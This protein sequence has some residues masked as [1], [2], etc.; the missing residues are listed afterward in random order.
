MVIGSLP[1][2]VFMITVIIFPGILKDGDC[3]W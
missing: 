3:F 2:V 1:I